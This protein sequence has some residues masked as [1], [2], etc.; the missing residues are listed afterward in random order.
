MNRRTRGR[1]LLLLPALCA[2][3]LVSSPAPARAQEPALQEGFFELFVQRLPGR[4]PI[5]TLVDSAGS[6]LVPLI[7]TLDH[8][9]IPWSA[10]GDTVQLE[11]PPGTWESTIHLSERWVR[12][13]ERTER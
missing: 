7:L 3:L 6:V 10:S 11:W 5:I 9:G 4:L 12:T 1:P 13:G 8:V 2:L